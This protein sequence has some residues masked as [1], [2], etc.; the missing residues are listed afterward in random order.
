MNI[1]GKNFNPRI[2]L[3]DNPKFQSWWPPGL[4]FCKNMQDNP[5]IIYFLKLFFRDTHYSNKKFFLKIVGL[6]LTMQF[7][8]RKNLFRK[9]SFGKRDNPKLRIIHLSETDRMCHEL[10]SF[11]S[12]KNINHQ[13]KKKCG[14]EILRD[15]YQW[16]RSLT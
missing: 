10:F 3:L 6:W 5:R 14:K 9:I 12:A 4:T 16:I 8:V 11:S 15:F 7:Y 2:I 1:A 13:D